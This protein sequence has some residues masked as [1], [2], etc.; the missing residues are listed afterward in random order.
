MDLANFDNAVK[1]LDTMK[2]YTGDL[3]NQATYQWGEK[4]DKWEIATGVPATELRRRAKVATRFPMSFR[5]RMAG[6][7][8]RFEH[9]EAVVPLDNEHASYF[10]TMADE[11]KW[12]IS[13]LKKRIKKG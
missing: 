10:L 6:R 8:L 7:N 4:Y 11:K 5:Q 2:W 9:F 3:I 13:E 12:S 1:Q